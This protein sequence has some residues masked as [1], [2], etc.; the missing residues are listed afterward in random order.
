MMNAPLYYANPI[1]RVGSVLR[2]RVDGLMRAGDI[3][4]IDTPDQNRRPPGQVS[5]CA[6]NGCFGEHFT[7]AKWW[8]WLSRQN[9]DGCIFAT[10]PDVV[11]TTDHGP[12]GDAAATLLRSPQWLPKIRALGFPAAYVAQDGWDGSVVPWD[13][14]DVL[15]IGGSDDFKIG[16]KPNIRLDGTAKVPAPSEVAIRE[17]QAH[18]KKVHV[19]RVNS[20]KRYRYFASLGVDSMDGTYL[21]KGH[22]LGANLDYLLTWRREALNNDPAALPAAA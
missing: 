15:F 16:G 10:A 9:P 1:G 4:C 11:H 2:A 12:V 19:G 17:A 21:L 22:P 3:G 6:D 20:L 18:G 8:R 7:E 14:F 5:W 13:E